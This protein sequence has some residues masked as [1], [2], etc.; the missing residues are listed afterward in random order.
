MPPPIDCP[1]RSLLKTQRQLAL[2]NLALRHQVSVLKRTVGTRR[3]QLNSGNRGSQACELSGEAVDYFCEL[4]AFNQA[5]ST[6]EQQRHYRQLR[7]F[8]R[9]RRVHKLDAAQEAYHGRWYI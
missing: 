2:E 6:A 5:Q 7:R 4:V 9:F 3:P 1:Y 8:R